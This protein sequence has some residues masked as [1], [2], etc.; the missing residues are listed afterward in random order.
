MHFKRTKGQ[1]RETDRVTRFKLI[2]SGKHWLRAATSYFGLFRVLKG[3]VD[4]ASVRV[5]QLEENAPSSVKEHLLKG[6]LTTGALLTGAATTYR[7]Q[8]D[9]SNDASALERAVS[10]A[11]DV[12][13]A[14]DSA[15]LGHS[16]ES[17][18]TQSQTE[19]ASASISESASVE[20][21]VSHSVSVSTSA[22]ES[23][24]TSAS[25]SASTSASES[26][27]TSASQS[28]STSASESASSS[29]SKST[30][31]SAS[32]QGSQSLTSEA[33]STGS[34]VGVQAGE[35]SSSTVAG[36]ASG[37]TPALSPQ[38]SSLTSEVTETA[39][40]AVAATTIETD[41]KRQE[42]EAKLTSLS[43]EI[44]TYLEKLGN[45]EGAESAL[46]KG[47]ATIEAIQNALT[48]PNADLNA[49]ISEATRTRNTVVNTVLR[50]SS[51]A[52]DY[53]NGARITAANTLRA[54]YDTNASL[55]NATYDAK[56]HLIVTNKNQSTY[57]KTTGD[58]S[59]SNGI[60]TLTPS[61]P[62]QAGAY[63]LN[64]K[65]DMSESFTLTGKINLGEAYEGRPK[66]G[67]D[68]GDG[69]AAVFSTG[70]IGEIGN[71]NGNGSGASLGMGGDNLK[72][73]FGFKLDTWHNTG[74]PLPN[75]KASADPK[76]SGY[77]KGA[78]GGFTYNYNGSNS[79]ARGS[80]YPVIRTITKLNGEGPTD[81]SLKDYKVVY[82]G[83]T[84]VMTVTYNGQTWSMNLNNDPIAVTGDMEVLGHPNASALKYENRSRSL[85]QNAGYP[86]EMAFALFGST[87]SGYNLQQFQLE[88]F[89][90]SAQGAYI[91][92]KF[93]DADTGEEIPG[94]DEV[95]IQKTP[96]TNVDLGEYL[97]IS[98]YTLKATNVSTAKGYVFGNTVKVVTG[99]QGI[100]YAFHKIRQNEIYTA[101]A[102]ATTVYT[103][104][105]ET[106]SDLSDVSKFVTV[107]SNESTTPAA[108][109]YS[110]VWS[111]PISTTTS[112]NQTAVA[113]VTYSDGSVQTVNV[114]YKVLPKIEAKTP[115]Y[116]FKGQN[117]HN[118]SNADAYL[119]SD[120]T[121]QSYTT[122]W[123]NNSTSSTTTTLPLSTATAGEFNYTITRTY[124][125]G[126]YGT[127]SNSSELLVSTTT[128]K[129]KVIE[130]KGVS[131]TFEQNVD[132]D[133][134][135]NSYT[136]SEWYSTDSVS[137]SAILSANFVS[138]DLPDIST[139]GQFT[140]SVRFTT[141]PDGT[142]LS[143][144]YEL[145]VPYTVTPNRESMSASTSA[146]VS[147][148]TSASMS[149]STSASE[150]A[151][152]SASASLSTKESERT[153]ESV[154]KSQSAST[155][156]SESAST[157]A[158]QSASTSAS[159]SASTSASQSAST[160][161][162]ESAST[163]ASQS[164][165]TSASESA[166]TSASQSAS[167]SASESASTSASQSAST[168]ASESASTSASQSA[169]TSASE[170]A[171]TSA[172]QS[173]STSASESASTSAS[174]SA[175]TSASNSVITSKGEPAI[176]SL[177]SIDINSV[178]ISDSISVS[179]SESISA[180]QSVST[181][182][183]ASASTSA[184]LSAS[185]SASA[186]A[187]TS[188]SMSASASAST[189]AS[190]SASTSASESAST[191]AS[192][193]ASTSASESASTSASLSTSISASAS[194]QRSETHAKLPQTGDQSANTAALGLGLLTGLVGLGV[195]AKRRKDEDEDGV[196]G[197]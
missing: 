54:S 50:A 24:S 49:L 62:S 101:S 8:A 67:H 155:S 185:T 89:D 88:K 68:G 102:K 186:S 151:S 52:R 40:T 118:G 63:T 75:N 28:A 60:L 25:E 90:Y 81:N 139:P 158:S 113:K 156:A 80:V 194:V 3:G 172:S 159:E 44:G 96:G 11:T 9:E 30:Q 154:L 115:I 6:L 146:S 179:V 55:G 71:A 2:K 78:F 184:S 18:Q 191:S 56:A 29:T 192:Q 152:T 51:G 164:A 45:R 65:I 157:S 197:Q 125:V 16:T 23:A 140:Y 5:P 188:A 114:N 20:A 10:P 36:L 135:Y 79:Q 70:A 69:I 116:D 103:L 27:S 176:H 196:T 124:D 177:D 86:D 61:A 134:Y 127:T 174:L 189:S 34:E 183:S 163:S 46:L 181:S 137:Q 47:K 193:S 100:T 22:S 59:L 173:A 138:S 129:H 147:A 107:A 66:N 104:Q 48:D 148:S 13:A 76:Y 168:S 53:R 38:A 161:A 180:S 97:A 57:F 169:S 131:H 121:D 77:Q 72:G 165:S 171:S 123:T 126:R 111:T 73:S 32:H 43:A 143:T 130:V 106:A 42:Q 109:G 144:T 182:A 7:V 128:L 95:L 160:S 136:P 167:T 153:S 142:G 117:L 145:E 166:S 132:D 93:I 82:D 19:A 105:G 87:G 17:S 175:S 190:M 91:T 37:E 12:L 149:A 4:K 141:L 35:V 119:S 92:V 41:K 85:L 39:T 74:N 83:D 14:S 187:S 110:L 170:S 64:T 1:Y 84:K 122:K 108:S 33:S 178:I 94:K 58:A 120:V 21:S 162:S 99:N 26:A 31:A 112:G 15:V 133:D 98:G 195:V 150:S